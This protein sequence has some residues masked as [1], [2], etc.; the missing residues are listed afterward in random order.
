[1]DDKA[2]KAAQEAAQ[3]AKS[4]KRFERYLHYLGSFLELSKQIYI[5]INVYLIIAVVVIR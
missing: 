5:L 4:Y 2:V 3:A 1:M